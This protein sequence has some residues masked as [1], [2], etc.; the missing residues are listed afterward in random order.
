MDDLQRQKD[1]IDEDARKAKEDADN[2]AT[3]EK[4]AVADTEA[5][6]IIKEAEGEAQ[7]VKDNAQN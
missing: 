3:E 7:Q 1:Q 4:Q 6:R 2:Q 5:N